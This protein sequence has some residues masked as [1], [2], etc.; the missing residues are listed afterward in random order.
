M[1]YPLQILILI[2]A[3]AS[4]SA[5]SDAISERIGWIKGEYRD[6]RENLGKY[7]NEKRTLPF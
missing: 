1:K 7:Q 2:S 3:I 5:L 6:T 4:F